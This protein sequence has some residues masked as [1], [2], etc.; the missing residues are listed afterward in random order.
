M[1]TSSPSSVRFIVHSPPLRPLSLY[2]LPQF[3]F[4]RGQ[5]QPQLYLLSPCSCTVWVKITPTRTP[6]L[7]QLGVSFDFRCN[8]LLPV[9]SP[10]PHATHPISHLSRDQLILLGLIREGRSRCLPLHSGYLPRC[11]T[12]STLP[13]HKLLINRNRNLKPLMLYLHR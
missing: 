13:L 10:S 3:S 9:Q 6:P 8:A 7:G 11:G 2:F 12:H 1:T 4:I 5:L